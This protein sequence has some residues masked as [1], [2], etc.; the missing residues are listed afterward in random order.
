MEKSEGGVLNAG[1]FQVVC[2]RHGAVKE[3][4]TF[5]YLLTV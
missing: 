5:K 2:A 4:S 1:T 3:Q